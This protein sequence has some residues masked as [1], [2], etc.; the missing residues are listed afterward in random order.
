MQRATAVTAPTPAA[1]NPIKPRTVDA[2]TPAAITSPAVPAVIKTQQ[3]ARALPPA[4]ASQAQPREPTQQAQHAQQARHA[5]Q[6]QHAQQAQ[7]GGEFTV[8][9]PR[10]G[11]RSTHITGP[12][13][14]LTAVPSVSQAKPRQ[15]SRAPRAAPAVKAAVVSSAA[16]SVAESVE[17]A[18]NGKQSKSFLKRYIPPSS[19]HPFCY[20]PWRCC[21]TS[22][23]L[24]AFASLVRF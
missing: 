5:Q 12:Q 21:R 3:T 17:S 11:R 9:S 23:M 15:V 6:T 8:V 22:C 18:G 14:S 13:G 19:H 7:H 10:H 1:P 20:G 24:R 2:S 4:S 16:P